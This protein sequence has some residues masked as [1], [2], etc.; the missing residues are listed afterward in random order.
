MA[1]QSRSCWEAKHYYSY[2]KLISIHDRIIG[3]WPPYWPKKIPWKNTLDDIH[4]EVFNTH[5]RLFEVRNV[6]WLM[7]MCC[8]FY[9]PKRL[10]SVKH[11]N[12]LLCYVFR[13]FWLVRME[14]ARIVLS[15]HF[16]NTV[17]LWPVVTAVICVIRL[18]AWQHCHYQSSQ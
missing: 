14:G 11:T 10:K 18:L 5:A 17:H 6:L 16:R 3:P 15:L 1:Q 13:T 9:D 12:W 8:G 4:P 7:L 2:N